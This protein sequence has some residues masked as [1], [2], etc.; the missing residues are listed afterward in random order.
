MNAFYRLSKEE[1]QTAAQGDDDTQFCLWVATVKG[2]FEVTINEETSTVLLVHWWWSKEHL[3]ADRKLWASCGKQVEAYSF[4]DK[5]VRMPDPS[6]FPPGSDENRFRREANTRLC[7]A[8]LQRAFG[9]HTAFRI[10][11]TWSGCTSPKR[12]NSAVLTFR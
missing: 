9:C 12:A 2:I 1:K 8:H 11:G 10:R 7:I 6:Q 4:D 3:K 5:E